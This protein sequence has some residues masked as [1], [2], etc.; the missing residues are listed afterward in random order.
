MDPV[1][2]PIEPT[3]LDEL[4]QS[5][6]GAEV[7]LRAVRADE[8][9]VAA[10]LM[11]SAS[12]ELRPPTPGAIEHQTAY[13]AAAVRARDLLVF[14][15]RAGVPVGSLRGEL[16]PLSE[17]RRELYISHIN[18]RPELRGAGLGTR[19]VQHL[20]RWAP[21]V[22]VDAVTLDYMADNPKVAPFYARLG[23]EIVGYDLLR[24]VDSGSTPQ[25]RLEGV[26]SAD[27]D[28]ERRILSFLLDR[29]GLATFEEPWWPAV[30]IEARLRALAVS[31][32][33]RLFVAERAGSLRGLCWAFRKPNRRGL[34]IAVTLCFEADG[35]RT[36]AH[37]LDALDAFAATERAIES[38][39]TLWQ[40]CT[41]ALEPARSRGY[42]IGRYK[43]RLPVR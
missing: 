30:S 29:R 21:T 10:E 25:E 27:A 41:F 7:T 15:E 3:Q 13:C 20:A 42:A 19:L 43:A 23:F 33:Q 38:Y 5:W 9:Q 34:P 22:A 26:R 31:G 16:Y 28:D 12:N 35:E 40:S 32:D 6:H 24:K 14:V 4:V 36:S 39:V 2:S 11:V 1:T 37:L 17:G 18:L 8:V